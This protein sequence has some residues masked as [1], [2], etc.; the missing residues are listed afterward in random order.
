MCW[1]FRRRGAVAS[2][3]EKVRGSSPLSST[4][5]KRTGHAFSS[6]PLHISWRRAGIRVRIA[7][8]SD[9]GGCGP[10][11]GVGAEHGVQDVASAPGQADEGVVVQGS[12]GLGDAAEVAGRSSTATTITH[13][14]NI[15]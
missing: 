2:R 9:G 6:G 10:V 15:R 1:D 8:S 3:N 12:T 11:R 4:D 7:L 13:S 5:V 14:Q